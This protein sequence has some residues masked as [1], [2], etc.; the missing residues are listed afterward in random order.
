VAS[1][2]A[3]VQFSSKKLTGGVALIHVALSAVIGKNRPAFVTRER[4]VFRMHFERTPMSEA[5]RIL[6]ELAAGDASAAHRLLPL[7]YGELHRLATHSMHGQ[8]NQHTLQPTALVNE[9]YLRLFDAPAAG[10]GTP[11]FRGRRHFLAIA[12]R[13]MRHVLI[14][15]ARTQNAQKRGAG[16]R[17]IRLDEQRIPVHDSHAVLALHEALIE[18]ARIDPEL[19]EVVELRFFGG[20]GVEEVAELQR[21]SPST[22]KRSWRIAKAWLRKTLDQETQE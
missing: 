5:T 15:H 18:L 16:D 19:A 10:G 22:V 14:D 9:V 3:D 12:A 2:Q 7:V 6:E 13:A 8:G 11:G 20:L 4:R 17:P 21:I 1:A